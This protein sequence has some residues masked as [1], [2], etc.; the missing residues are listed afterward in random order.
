MSAAAA[1]ARRKSTDRGRTTF[2]RAEIEQLRA[3]VR[4][5][6][7]VDPSPQQMLRTRMRALGFYI[8]DFGDSAGFTVSGLD[9]LL[10]RGTVSVIEQA[11]PH[12][13]AAGSSES[14][15]SSGVPTSSA[16]PRK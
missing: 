5:K 14:P 7:T 13:A 10:T 15:G 12:D 11:P 16:V 1:A 6:Q 4:E 3:L 2:T 9:D 8:S